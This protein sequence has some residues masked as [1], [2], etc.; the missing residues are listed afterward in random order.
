MHAQVAAVFPRSVAVLASEFVMVIKY[1]EVH[2]PTCVWSCSVPLVE[3]NQL[4]QTNS[5]DGAFVE[6]LRE[7]KREPMYGT[8]AQLVVVVFFPG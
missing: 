7:L 1:R 5:F 4:V 3:M 2:S 8:A 6:R